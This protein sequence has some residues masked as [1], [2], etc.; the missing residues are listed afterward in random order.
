MRLM[1]AALPMMREQKKGLII[2]LSSTSGVRPSPGWDIYAAYKFAIEGLSEAVASLTH[3]WNI[4]VVVVEPGT[5]LTDFMKQS[6]EI[7]NRCTNKTS[8]TSCLMQSYGCKK[9]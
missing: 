3:Q 6:T 8:T 1:Q 4:D 2:N 7:G 9:D 5:T